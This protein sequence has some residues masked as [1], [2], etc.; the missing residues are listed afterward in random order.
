MAIDSVRILTDSAGQL[1]QRLDTYGSLDVLS[2][3]NSCDDWLHNV[4][5]VR[6]L[7]RVEEL[8]LRRDYLRLY[9][10]LTQIEIL[11]K[12]KIRAVELVRDRAINS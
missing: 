4:S 9:C 2:T 1:W 11:V 12:S 3:G 5:L 8:Q 7:T 10:L 6:P